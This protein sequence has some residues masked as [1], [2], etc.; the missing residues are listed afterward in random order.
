M[1]RNQSKQLF[2]ALT[3][4]LFYTV[5]VFFG[6]RWHGLDAYSWT[7]SKAAFAAFLSITFLALSALAFFLLRQP[8]P[9]P[10]GGGRATNEWPLFAQ[11][12]FF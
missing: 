12:P 6:M 11:N 5:L 7:S 9:L 1:N 3:F 10:E 4:S 2:L 8:V